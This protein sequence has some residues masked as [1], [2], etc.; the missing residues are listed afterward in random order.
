MIACSLPGE[1]RLG[2]WKGSYKALGTSAAL[3]HQLYFQGVP[4]LS[5]Q[6]VPTASTAPSMWHSEVPSEH[7]HGASPAA[8]T[9]CRSGGVGLRIATP[10][11]Q[12]EESPR[13]TPASPFRSAG[14]VSSAENDRARSR[15]SY[16]WIALLSSIALVLLL[17]SLLMLHHEVPGAPPTA[18]TTRR[19]APSPKKLF[20]SKLPEVQY[21]CDQGSRVTWSLGK[22]AWCCVS[23]DKGCPSGW[24]AAG[25]ST[26]FSG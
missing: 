21:N 1:L 16:R 12:R 22:I 20:L 5:S 10:E 17:V 19:K 2:G 9:E 8:H 4:R 13:R 15:F 18:K 11:K 24:R 26:Q 14:A 7:G 23:F 25:N 3:D 6:C